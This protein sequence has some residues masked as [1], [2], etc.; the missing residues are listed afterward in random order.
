VTKDVIESAAKTTTSTTGATPVIGIDLLTEP[1]LPLVWEARVGARIGCAEEL[2]H[3]EPAALLAAKEAATKVIGGRVQN[4][5]L[6]DITVVADSGGELAPGA[7][8]A[9]RADGAG[10]TD[11]E[12]G[13]LAGAEALAAIRDDIGLDETDAQTI[14]WSFDSSDE[15]VAARLV[16]GG[17]LVGNGILCQV[18]DLY[19][20]LC[21]GWRETP[22]W[23]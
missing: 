22:L 11:G 3:F 15:D 17:P 9:D 10:A 23:A 18:G 19:L 12:S 7:D 20:A 21:L 13:D 5:S 8:R 2:V 16:G 1:L 6:R 4:A 14:H